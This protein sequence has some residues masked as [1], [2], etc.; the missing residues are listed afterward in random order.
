MDGDRLERVAVAL[1]RTARQS[2][3]P[4]ARFEVN[5][6]GSGLR[7]S[8]VLPAGSSIVNIAVSEEADEFRLHL[9]AGKTVC[10]PKKSLE[11]ADGVPAQGA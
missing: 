1:N 6:D 2:S 11:A 3:H 4:S 8:I 10:I 7:Y 9:P 5:Q